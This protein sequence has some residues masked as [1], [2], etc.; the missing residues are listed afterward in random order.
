MNPNP[1]LPPPASPQNTTATGKARAWVD[2]SNRFYHNHWVEIC[3]A[4]VVLSVLIVVLTPD[5]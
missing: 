2:K 5:A 4:I 3:L 1:Q